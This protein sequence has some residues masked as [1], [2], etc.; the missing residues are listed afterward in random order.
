MVLSQSCAPRALLSNAQR[1]QALD[2]RGLSFEVHVG[3]IVETKRL[4]VQPQV[5]LAYETYRPET[6]EA[7]HAEWI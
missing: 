4:P 2:T 3:T 7:S 5:G 1:Q 6:I